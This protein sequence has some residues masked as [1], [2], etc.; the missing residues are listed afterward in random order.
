MKNL[1]PGLVMLLCMGAS[2]QQVAR[3][4]TASNGE[5][6]G[7]YEYKP[8]DYNVD[9]TTKYP[10][11]V[12][13]HGIGERGNG[14]S[15]LSRVRANGIPKYINAGHPMRFYWNGR[16]QSFIVLSPQLS[17]SYGWWQDFYIDEMIKYAKQNLRIDT[18]RIIL[19]G[20]SLGGGGVWEY[21][22]RSVTNASQFSAIGICCPTCQFP[23]WCNIADAQLPTWAFHAT[24]DGTT[25]SSCTNGA[26]NGIMNCG[27]AVKPYLT[28]W[29]NGG[30]GIWDRAYDTGYTWQNPNIFE[31]FLGQDKSLPVNKRPK[32]NAGPD[33]TISTNTAMATLSASGSQ[34]ED[35]RLVRYVWRK[36]DG[37]STGTIVTPVSAN[38]KTTINNLT[39][40]GTYR[41][42]VKV[43]DDRADYSLDTV[44]VRVVS[45]TVPN[46]APVAEAGP[47]HRV[48]LGITNLDASESYDPDG[49]VTS[50][51]WTKIAGPNSY[52]LSS[53]TDV[54]PVL[55]N[56]QIGTYAF[57]LRTT[58]NM[59]AV[60]FDTVIIY[61]VGA[62]LPVTLQYFKGHAGSKG[63]RLEWATATEYQNDRFEIERSIDG[64]QFV[65]I[66]AVKGSE[67]ST[68]LRTYH[69]I[70]ELPPPGVVYYRLR[71]VGMDGKATYLETITVSTHTIGTGN[72]SYYP[73]PV[74][75]YLTVQLTG[76]EHG[77][78][79]IVLYSHDGRIVQQKQ[80]VK[81]QHT[82]TTGLDMRTIT[83][84]IY[85]LEVIIDDRLKA[86]RKVVKQ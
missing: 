2:G 31:W 47:D 66:G 22:A 26:I 77:T 10:L 15:E 46:I 17:S 75:D 57:Q 80:V 39:I 56:L 48:Q 16:W 11:I 13:L 23:N 49:I 74:H 76:K 9:P 83:K 60:S 63:N 53:N 86:V 68:A 50:Y 69:F 24:N 62:E 51:T 7:F 27:A 45:G 33:L 58:D 43:I 18:N 52:T 8:A 55:S 5:Y 84:G 29:D 28:L 40:A 73:N 70:D 14:T 25:P 32:A 12:F 61:S 67:Q 1:L 36:I 65:T 37:P 20:L 78:A 44:T 4:L 38:G 72:L 35:G 79:R 34:D 30:H 3:G 59:G 64:D 42:E 81:Q 71:Q 54:S 6:I 85:L 82:L 21:A 19:T 41:F